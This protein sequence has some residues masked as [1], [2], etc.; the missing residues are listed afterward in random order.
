MKTRRLVSLAFLLGLSVAL[1]YLESLIPFSLIPGFKL[2]LSNIVSLFVLYYYGGLSFVF[3]TVLR[4]ILVG[5]IS[6]GFVSPSFLMSLS[7]A[8]LSGIVS[9]I[10][11]YL[12]KTSIYGTSIVSSLFHVLGQ[13]LAYA[14][15]FDSFYIFYYVAILGPLSLVTGAL[16]ALLCSVLIRRL[17]NI[18]RT[19][20][21]KRR[22]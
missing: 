12:V 17:P 20:E 1:H 19:E 10:L 2:G 21:K 13:L 22:T 4:V 7:G 11:Y 3:V 9:L 6:S 14:L 16:I 8:L 18:F 5:A 15:F